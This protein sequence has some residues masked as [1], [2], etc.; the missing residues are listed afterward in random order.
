MPEETKT[1]SN[2]ETQFVW[3]GPAGTVRIVVLLVTLGV[4]IYLT[5]Q[6]FRFFVLMFATAAPVAILMT[7]TQERLT[8]GLGNRRWLAALILV[9]WTLLIVAIPFT[10]ILTLLGSQAVSFFSWLGPQLEPAKVQT[11]LRET[12]PQKIPWFGAMWVARALHGSH[13]R[14]PSLPDLRRGPGPPAAA[15]L[16]ARRHR[17]RGLALLPLP[18]LLPAGWRGILCSR[19]PCL[20]SRRSRNPG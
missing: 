9:L 18:L 19:A 8:A 1:A 14:E 7:P 12:L 10:A 6:T 20:R 3:P 13:G 11:L 15:R 2:G 17:G 5:W 16:G 4:V